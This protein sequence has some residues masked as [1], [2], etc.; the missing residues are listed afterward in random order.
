MNYEQERDC[1]DH[2]DYDDRCKGGTIRSRATLKLSYCFSRYVLETPDGQRD[3]GFPFFPSL[4]RGA[5]VPQPL[6]CFK[7]FHRRTRSIRAPRGNLEAPAVLHLFVYKLSMYFRRKLAGWPVVSSA[8]LHLASVGRSGPTGVR[9]RTVMIEAF[10]RECVESLCREMD[11]KM[12]QWKKW[13]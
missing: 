2:R 8:S 4:R 11:S 3:D 10:E 12:S 1:R 13:I 7:C 5:L 6:D 9:Q